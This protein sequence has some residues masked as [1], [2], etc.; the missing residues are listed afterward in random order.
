M[1]QI[2]YKN[3]CL[4][5]LATYWTSFKPLSSDTGGVSC[6]ENENIVRL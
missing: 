4:R 1:I 5:S 6:Y 2:K 3:V